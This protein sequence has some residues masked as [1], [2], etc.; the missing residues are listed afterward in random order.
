MLLLFFLKILFAIGNH[1]FKLSSIIQEHLVDGLEG[2]S[3]HKLRDLPA[4]IMIP[5]SNRKFLNIIF[6]VPFLSLSVRRSTVHRM[7]FAAQKAVFM[8][9]EY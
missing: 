5:T 6:V 8:Q 4:A 2:P 7:L 9:H 3:N 1:Q